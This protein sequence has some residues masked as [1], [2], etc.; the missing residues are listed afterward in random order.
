MTRH[1]DIMP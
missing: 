1:L